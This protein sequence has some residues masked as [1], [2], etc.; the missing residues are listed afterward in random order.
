MFKQVKQL[1]STGPNITTN[2]NLKW[3]PVMASQTLEHMDMKMCW[4]T[5]AHKQHAQQSE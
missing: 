2:T 5:A 4:C 3:N 1:D